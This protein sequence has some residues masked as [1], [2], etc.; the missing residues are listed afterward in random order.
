[1]IEHVSSSDTFLYHYTKATTA[2]DCIFKNRQLRIGSY[3]NTNDPKESRA[4]EFDLG[5]NEN[6]DLGKYKIS[7]MSIWLSAELK[8]RT[9]LVCFSRDTA[10]LT[11]DH[12]KDIFNRGFSKPR[13]W[14]QYADRHTGVCIV[15]DWI[16]LTRLIQSQFGSAH[17]VLGGPVSYIDH[18]VVGNLD[19]REYM[20]NV[21]ALEI[22]GRAAYVQAHLRAHHKSLFFEKMTDWGD[23]VEWR[24]VVFSDHQADIYLNLGDSVAGLMFG[25]NTDEKIIQDLMDL[26]ESWDLRYMGLKWKN[27]SPWYDYRNLR[28]VRGIKNSGWDTILRRV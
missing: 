25:E 21:D 13:M 3:A 23:E 24:W 2:R 22:L 26:T 10:T 11:G 16:K 28:Y 12:L 1:M 9:N 15:F 7:D 6:R 14:A 5:T 27:S 4:W 8:Q 20:I 19:S 17:L 18:R